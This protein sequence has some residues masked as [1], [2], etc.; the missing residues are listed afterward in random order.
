M[1]NSPR[2][3]GE[4]IEQLFVPFQLAGAGGCPMGLGV[5]QRIVQQHGGEV[6]VR[7]EGEWGA[8]V[9]LTLPV[10]GNEDRRGPGA[11][12]RAPR[13]DRRARRTAI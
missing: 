7:S 11:D 4:L 2:I 1:P 3:S 10:R 12:R 5:A 8:I 6:R 9:S 13:V